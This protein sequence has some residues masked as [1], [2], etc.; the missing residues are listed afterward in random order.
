MKDQGSVERGNES[1]LKGY[2]RQHVDTWT[3]QH[4]RGKDKNVRKDK[5]GHS[6]IKTETDLNT[7]LSLGT[8]REG[9]SHDASELDLKPKE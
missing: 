6:R 4:P 9:N 5:G 3:V 8:V 7:P 1:Q 2:K